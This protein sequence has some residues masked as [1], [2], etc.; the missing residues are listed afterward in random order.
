M[1]QSNDILDIDAQEQLLKDQAK[2]QAHQLHI[3]NDDTKW[4]MSTKKGRRIVWR[5]LEL[6]RV[7]RLSYDTNPMAMAFNEGN[8]NFG[9]QLLAEIQSLCPERY[10]EMLR[11]NNHG[12]KQRKSS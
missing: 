7:F 9:N 3:Q 1:P 11:E 2:E 5:L 8:R 6:A 12:S 4:L 10:L